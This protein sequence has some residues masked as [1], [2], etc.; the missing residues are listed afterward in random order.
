MQIVHEVIVQTKNAP[1]GASILIDQEDLPLVSRL[2]LSLLKVIA[3]SVISE[4][5]SLAFVGELK[6]R[7]TYELAL[8]QSF[9]SETILLLSFDVFQPIS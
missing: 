5:T 8:T 7:L 6:R 1:G 4:G 9:A 3:D 2:L